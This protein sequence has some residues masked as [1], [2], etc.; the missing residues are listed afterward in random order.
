V[1]DPTT[2][3][4]YDG[5]MIIRMFEPCTDPDGVGCKVI[6]DPENLH[7]TLP[8]WYPSSLRI[9]DGSLM[10]VGGIQGSTP[11]YNNLTAGANSFEFFPSK[12][13]GLARPSPF[14]VRTLP[15][16]LFP[17]AFALPDGQVLMIANNQTILYDI[18]TDTETPLPDIPNGVRVT[19]PFD[20]TATLLPLTP[21]L[22]TPEVLV[23]GG[24]NVSDSLPSKA[25][26]VND[27][28]SDQCSRMI[29][30]KEGIA[31]G[32]ELERM[33]EGHILSEMVMLPDGKVLLVNGARTGYAAVGS[34]KDSINGSSNANNPILTPLLY[35]PN[36]PLG[37]RFSREGLPTTNIPRMYHSTA[38]LTPAGNL[39]I[40]GSNPNVNPFLQP[41][42]SV[43]PSEFRAEYLNPPYMFQNRPALHNV[44]ETLP[45]NH[46][47]TIPVDVPSS[48]NANTVQVA[49][50]DLGYSTH[51]FKASSRVVF[52][53]AT[54]A[55][56]KK[57]ITITTPPNN[58]VYPPGPGWIFITVDGVS[59]AG[60][61]VL[62]GNGKP[63]PVE[64]QGVPLSNH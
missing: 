17:R 60:T 41:N 15:A 36:A 55:S 37:Q 35:D 52:M 6:E 12:D 13:N 47:F 40:A 51:A 54:L 48:L 19:N 22:F 27:P 1:E 61:H 46:E 10:V 49:L 42:A 8:R 7:L 30:T 26:S 2:E 50:I 25:L 53:H 44:P 28:A 16:N 29:L 64:D 5:R 11:F 62:I 59:S 23:C 38:T 32:W 14:L 39:L 24:T 58:K 43:Y 57:S 20:G 63:P 56:N 21:P 9:S 4:D 3:T 33:P 18:A 34:V 45:F 31:K